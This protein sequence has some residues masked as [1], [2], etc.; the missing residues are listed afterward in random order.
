MFGLALL[1]KLSHKA[2]FQAGRISITCPNW[3]AL[4]TTIRPPLAAARE[5]RAADVVFQ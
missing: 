4:E 3:S 5:H 1:E 2:R